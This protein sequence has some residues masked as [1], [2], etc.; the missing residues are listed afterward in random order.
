MVLMDRYRCPDGGPRGLFVGLCT[1]DLAYLVS[2]FPSPN[3]KIAADRQEL[4]A[5]GPATNAAVTFS[6][7]GGSASLTTALGRHPLSSI[8]RHDLKKWR[9]ELE[10]IAPDHGEAPPLSSIFIHAESGERTVVSANAAAYSGLQY[11]VNPV[12]PSSAQVLL[13]DGHYMPHCIAAAKSARDASVTVVLDGGSWKSGMS[14]LLPFV[15]IAICS[16]D[17]A[18]PE[19]GGH[20]DAIR[21]LLASGVPMVA[22]TRG[23]KPIRWVARTGAGEIAIRPIQPRDTL[24]AGDIFHGAFCCAYACGCDFTLALELA[25]EIAIESCLHFGTRSWMDSFD[26]ARWQLPSLT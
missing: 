13:V 14:D 16:E 23:P 11:S 1:V 19:A 10:D 21:H 6:F 18:P 24:G 8:I 17:F 22:V 9:V 7:L 26:V 2:R 12:V 20:E 5:G 15:D 25:S 3:R 4:T